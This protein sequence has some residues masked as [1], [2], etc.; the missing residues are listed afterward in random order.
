VEGH[1]PTLPA[2]RAGP[3]GRNGSSR[4]D[5]D[6]VHDFSGITITGPGLNLGPERDLI[7]IPSFDPNPTIGLGVHPDKVHGIQGELPNLTIALVSGVV[8]VIVAPLVVFKDALGIHTERCGKGK[9]EECQ[10]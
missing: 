9:E 8:V 10:Q 6:V 1:G 3:F 4:V 2:T 5:G 7:P